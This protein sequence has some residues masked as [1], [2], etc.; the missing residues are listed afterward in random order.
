MRT[1]RTLPGGKRTLHPSWFGM[2][3]IFGFLT[4]LR[5]K[6]WRETAPLWLPLG[7]FLVI[8]FSIGDS[9]PRYL[10]P[11]DWIGIIFVGV[12][13]DWI[14]EWIWRRPAPNAPRTSVPAPGFLRLRISEPA[15]LTFDHVPRRL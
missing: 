5:P 1:V 12:G 6:R 7:L 15:A 13:L 9:V 10:Q 2:L 14:L 4:C 3:A 8:I 11:V